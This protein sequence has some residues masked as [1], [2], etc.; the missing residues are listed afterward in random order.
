VWYD[1]RSH[2][3]AAGDGMETAPPVWPEGKRAAPG[4]LKTKLIL[5]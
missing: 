2:P 3:V 1:R 5:A 4:P